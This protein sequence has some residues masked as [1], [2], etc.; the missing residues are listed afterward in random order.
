LRSGLE[1]QRRTGAEMSREA[2][3]NLLRLARFRRMHGDL[4]GARA[5]CMDA[6]RIQRE[7]L[8]ADHVDVAET[9]RLLGTISADQ[10]DGV[11]SE[12]QFRD[13]LEM[14][15]RVVG[16]HGNAVGQSADELA[17]RLAEQG[18]RAEAAAM[19]RRAADARLAGHVEEL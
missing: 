16:P 19:R 6:L 12:K 1:L 9:L 10:G 4:A 7:V 14:L 17:F 18:R 15:E 8:P 2:A 11:A 13:A 3:L 5:D